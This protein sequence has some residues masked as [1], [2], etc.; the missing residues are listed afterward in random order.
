VQD[1]IVYHSIQIIKQLFLKYNK[2]SESI[3]NIPPPSLPYLP[4]ND[5]EQGQRQDNP[6]TRLK[7]THRPNQQPTKTTTKPNTSLST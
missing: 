6:A 1:N 5:Q 4:S 7:Q 3:E 2:L